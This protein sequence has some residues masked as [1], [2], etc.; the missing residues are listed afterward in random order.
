MK[1]K[2]VVILPITFFIIALIV[3]ILALPYPWTPLGIWLEK[4]FVKNISDCLCLCPWWL[5]IFLQILISIIL[6]AF[7]STKEEYSK[8]LYLIIFIINA[9]LINLLH[10]LVHNYGL[11]RMLFSASIYCRYFWFISLL[12][13]LLYLLLM[14]KENKEQK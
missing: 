2:L 6:R 12:V 1:N 3:V 14:P 13:F 5:F 7:F 11:N 9:L 4:F 10:L 8:L